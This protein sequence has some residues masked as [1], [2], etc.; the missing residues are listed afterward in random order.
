[1]QPA[2]AA[3]KAMAA[4]VPEV[5][6]ILGSGLGPLAEEIGGMSIPY[7][8]IPGMPVSSAPGHAGSLVIGYLE[9]RPVVAMQGRVH[10]YEGFDAAQCSFPVAL[11]AGLGARSLLVSNA[12]GGLNPHFEAGDIMLQRDLIN[13][14]G[15]NP[16]IGPVPSPDLERFPVMFECYDAEYIAA[17]RGA[18]LRHGIALREGVYLAITGPS[19]ATRAE[20]RAFRTLGADA[21]GMSTV[22]E[23][24][25]ARQLG[26]R[27]VGL[28][29]V[30]DMAI[31][32]RDAH[33]TGDEVIAM[34]QRSGDTFRRLVR[35]LLPEL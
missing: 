28:S 23:V 15:Q 33:A 31:A 27:V 4:L 5:A 11:M 30:T 26:L 32:D 13:M 35:A 17:A 6:I 12:C 16:L 25:R 9:G 1:M 3:V 34:A 14:T 10:P 7:A 29:V 20:L 18:A 19:Y 22:F 24:I 2:I 8:D 21:I